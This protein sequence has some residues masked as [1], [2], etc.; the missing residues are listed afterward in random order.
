MERET[1]QAVEEK[2]EKKYQWIKGERTTEVV[3]VASDQQDGKWL[4]F[5][6]GTRINPNLINEFLME[7]PLSASVGLQAPVTQVNPVNQPVITVEN[8]PQ[9]VVKEPSIMGKMIMKMSKKNVVNVPIQININ[10]PTP[11]LYAMLSDGMEEDDLNEEIMAVVSE[12]I[13]INKLKEY[14]NESVLKS[15]AE[16]YSNI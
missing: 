11:Q 16:Y 15:I 13:E 4:Y 14:I 8:V 7:V 3:Q 2:Q 6:D 12:Q 5:T 1:I 10:I 9:V